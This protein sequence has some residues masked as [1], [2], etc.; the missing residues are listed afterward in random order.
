[1]IRKRGRGEKEKRRSARAVFEGPRGAEVG[2]GKSGMEA[3]EI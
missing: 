2:N 1:L 3:P